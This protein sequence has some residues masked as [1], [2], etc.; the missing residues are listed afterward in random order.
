LIFAG[1]SCPGLA[2]LERKEEADELEKYL[3][4]DPKA[5]AAERIQV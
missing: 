4:L 3:K 5:A 2:G 1:Y